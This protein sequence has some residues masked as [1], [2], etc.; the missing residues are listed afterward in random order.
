MDARERH[1]RL[2]TETI[3]AVN[4]TLDLQ[5][6]LE[7]VASKV[8]EALD[9]DACFVYLYDERA[10]ELVLRATHG[11]SVEEMTRRPK[12]RPG[13]GITGTA[14]AERA[15]VMI[16]AEAHLDPRFKWFKNLPEEQYESILAVPILAREKLEGALNVR[17]REP[18]EFSQAEI[19]LVLAIAAQVAQSIEHAKL[20]SQAQRRVEELEAL[21][22]ISEAVSESLYLEES[23]EA[24]VK[25]TMDAVA[26]TGAALVLEDGKIAWPE[27]RAGKYAVRTPLRWK[28]RQIGEL[29]ADRDTPFTDEER[30]LLASIAHH[31]AVALEHGRAVMRGVLA[32]EIHHR[33][34][35]NLQTVASLLRLQARGDAVDPRRALEDSV[36]RILA[37]AA[38]HEVLTERR[39]ESVDLGDLLERLRAML[40]QG[41]GGGKEVSAALAPVTLEGA[42][43]TALALVFSELLQNAL[44]HG[45]TSVRIE[46]AERNGD[47][48][49]AIADDG[50]GI[51]GASQGTGLSIVQALVRD[52]LGG[53]LS[54]ADD[55]GLRAE[56]VFPA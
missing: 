1:L 53:T 55:G 41:L 26:A 16:P 28:R 11:T 2:L 45:G 9:T 52:E 46:L 22:R 15:P 50:G 37:I 51:D 12:M 40:V 5:E 25:T 42:R 3:A 23:L 32:Q 44:E 48:V 20:Y 7:L 13:E 24:I 10:D 8:A 17:T 56:V 6:V 49:L 30:A 33:V 27:G 47:V 19:D 36:N 35:N 14:A 39:D 54:L 38:V 43:A 21:A 4:S 31:A 29:V 18:R 34:K